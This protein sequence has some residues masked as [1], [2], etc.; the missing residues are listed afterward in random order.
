MLTTVVQLLFQGVNM[1]LIYAL[2]GIGISLIWNAS[3]L[4]NFS[5]GD[6]LTL[7]GYAMLTLFAMMELSYPVA[8]I[9]T[10][11]IMGCTGYI[12]SKFYFYP[13]FSEGL[14]QQVILIGTVSLSVLIRNSILLSWGADPHTFAN[15]FGK[16]PINLFGVNV[17]PHYFWNIIIVAALIG[18]LQLFLR[19]TL[20]GT[21]MRAVAQRPYAATLMGIKIE[22]MISLTFLLST[23]LAAISGILIAPIL[24]L[25]PEMG[26]LVNTKAF[27]AVLIGGLGSFAGALVGGIIIGIA[28]VFFATLITASYKDVFI[29]LMLIVFLMFKPGGIFEAKISEKV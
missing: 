20:I 21:A 11:V 22:H 16:T 10:I 13:M 14:D 7:G 2:A 17:M 15:P 24:P 23:S 19:G 9:G 29:F 6:L 5:Q 25:T 8:L 1:G 4:F 12:L 26:G 27:A 18:V 3:S 28:E